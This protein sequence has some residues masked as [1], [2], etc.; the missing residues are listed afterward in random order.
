MNE[1]SVN[2]FGHALYEPVTVVTNLLISFSC[3]YFFMKLRSGTDQKL[4]NYWRFFFFY[5][6]L[7]TFIGGIAHGFK[8]YFSEQGFYI[9]WMTMNLTSIPSSYY[10]LKAT[11]ETTG[12]APETKVKLGYAAIG[13]AAVLAILTVILNNFVLIKINAGIVILLTIIRHAVLLKK[14]WPGAVY[15]LG[16]FAFSLSSLVVHTAKLSLS[17]WFNFKDISH[18]IMNISLAVIFI[19]VSLKT[20]P[21]SLAAVK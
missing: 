12:Y 4:R 1:T 20:R 13:A 6:G 10:L 14:A 3:A 2:I 21:Q 11:I 17:D 19:G 7:S 18:V 8:P 5:I 15:I 9:L 16:G